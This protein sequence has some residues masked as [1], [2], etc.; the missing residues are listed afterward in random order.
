MTRLDIPTSISPQRP[1]AT[2]FD[3]A[4]SDH[5]GFT[6]VNFSHSMALLAGPTPP[7]RNA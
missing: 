4:G 1:G 7:F 5:P 3:R 6:A 2:G